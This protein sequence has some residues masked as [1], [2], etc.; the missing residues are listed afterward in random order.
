MS[1]S[2]MPHP[3][4]RHR[5]M[6]VVVFNDGCL[7]KMASDGFMAS[8]LPIYHQYWAAA[9]QRIPAEHFVKLRDKVSISFMS[10][11]SKSVF[12][13]TL[14]PILATSDVC[15]VGK[16]HRQS[17]A[18]LS[19]P[20]PLP[21]PLSYFFPVIMLLHLSISEHVEFWS[22]MS[23]FAQSPEPALHEFI[24][25]NGSTSCRKSRRWVVQLN[26]IGF[27]IIHLDLHVLLPR[28]D[29]LVFFLTLYRREFLHCLLHDA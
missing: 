27:L 19:F 25:V 10:I 3:V 5:R 1:S 9:T 14:S 20:G 24:L 26:R 21:L 13:F 16:R 11:G 17:K 6:Q 12:N 28:W 23:I 7:L 18:N 2:G 15:Q 29:H 8:R 4:W 22:P